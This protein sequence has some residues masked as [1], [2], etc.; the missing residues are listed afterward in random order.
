MNPDAL[1]ALLVLLLGW[2]VVSGRLERLDMTGPIIFVAAGL[3]LC[4]GP[5]AV[6]DITIE[7]HAVH[8]LAEV[9][10]V[11][12]L[13]ADAAQV[14]PRELRHHAALPIRL[15][16]FGLPLTLALGAAVAA[17]LLTDLPW[18][19]A[20][21]LGAVLAPTDAA[22]SASVVSDRSLP[23]AIRRSL[24]VESGLNDGIVTPIVTALI[25]AAATLIGVGV[26]EDTAS[27]SGA[28]ALIDLGGGVLIGGLVGYV[29]GVM[30]TWARAHGWIA[31]GGRRIAVLTLPFL[32]FLVADESGVNYFVAAFIAGFAF[33]AGT[34]REDEEA[35]ELPE[36][37][38]RVFS[39]AVWGVFGA[40]LLLDG[41]ERVDWRIALYAVLSLTVVRMLPV[42]ISMIG[43]GFSRPATLFVGWF[44]PRGLA[45]VVFGLLIVEELPVGD[46]RV[47]TVLSTIVLT[48]L[49]SVIAHGISGRPFSAWMGRQEPTPEGSTDEVP[50]LSRSPGGRPVES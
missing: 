50:S 7:S 21:L 49:L 33:R 39:L 31:P 45:S 12:L 29:G 28:D 2:H 20:A 43:A 42:A 26:V 34:G 3:L 15:L 10:L 9:T 22:L 25:A 14:N 36:L 35:T 48:V 6:V 41:L 44:G 19:L 40:G 11:L 37:I 1:I 24:N 16:A 17:V 5:W 32:A 8:A 30:V 46:P 38:G 27:A 18:E 13:F 47:E 4:N 23:Q